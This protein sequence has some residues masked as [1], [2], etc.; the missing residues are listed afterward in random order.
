[1]HQ[2]IIPSALF[3]WASILSADASL[4]ERRALG[5]PS[6]PENYTEV[7]FVEPIAAPQL[8]AEEQRGYML[9]HR[10]STDPVYPNTHPL[11]RERCRVLEA[12]AAQGE[13]EPL[14]VS[15]YP[16]PGIGKPARHRFGTPRR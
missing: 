5:Q 13:F 12:F 16:R 10:P 9:F 1:M 7:P 2:R 3:L 8:T 6:V 11:P 15:I 14:A 4:A